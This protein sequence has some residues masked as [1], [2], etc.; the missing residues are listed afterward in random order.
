MFAVKNIFSMRNKGYDINSWWCL[1]RFSSGSSAVRAVWLIGQ[2]QF[3]NLPLCK[4]INCADRCKWNIFHMNSSVSSNS[5]LTC[6]S[7]FPTVNTSSRRS[8]KPPRCTT[9]PTCYSSSRVTCLTPRRAGV[10]TP[11][12]FNQHTTPSSRAILDLLSDKILWGLTCNFPCMFSKPVLG[13]NLTLF[14]WLFSENFMYKE[15]REVT[16]FPELNSYSL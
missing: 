3:E 13:Q 16:R 5:T 1:E 6:F 9:T 15:S 10:P 4:L 2:D 14:S 8:S 12:L 11:T 7:L